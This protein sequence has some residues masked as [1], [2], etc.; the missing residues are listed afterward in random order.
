MAQW[1][2]R[3]LP[4]S[5]VCGSNPVIGKFLYGIFFTD[6]QVWGKDENKVKEAGNGT[7]FYKKMYG[8]NAFKDYTN[9]NVKIL[10]SMPQANFRV[11]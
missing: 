10:Q 8:D 9:V 4:T 1:V 6:C 3:S 11:D 2:K 5:E 7:F